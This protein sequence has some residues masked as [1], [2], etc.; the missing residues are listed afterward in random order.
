MKRDALSCFR[1]IRRGLPLFLCFIITFPFAFSFSYVLAADPEG[2]GKTAIANI[3]VVDGVRGDGYLVVYTPRFGNTTATNTH[4]AEAVVGSDNRVTYVGTNNN[5]TIPDGGFVVSGHDS[6]TGNKM[7]KWITDNIEVGDYVYFNASAMV[8]VVSGKALEGDG[9]YYEVSSVLNSINKGRGADAMVV[10]TSDYGEKTG[11]NTYG[12]EV[13]VRGGFVYSVGG[14]NNEIPKDGFVVSGHG[15]SAAFLKSYAVAGMKVSYS[16]DD[17]NKTITF[18]YNEESAINKIKASLDASEVFMESQKSLL[19]YLNY[20]E[21]EDKIAAARIDLEEAAGETDETKKVR[22]IEILEEE[23]AVIHG[24]LYESRPVEYRNVW[25]CP[26]QKTKEEVALYVESLFETGINSVS[27]EVIFSSTTVMPMPEDSLFEQD[28]AFG[29]FDV[30]ESFIDECHKRDMELNAW[31][32]VFCVGAQK[33]KN[34]RRSVYA[35]KKEWCGVNSSGGITLADATNHIFLNPANDECVDFLLGTYRWI[36]ESYDL[37]GFE[38]DYI[39]YP[40]VVYDDFGYDSLTVSKFQAAYKTD[41]VPEYD[42]SAEYWSDWCDFRRSLVTDFVGKVRELVDSAAPGVTLLADVGPEVAA[43][44][45]E[46]YQDYTVWLE[47]GYIDILKPM[48]YYKAA[49][50]ETNKK[51]ALTEGKFLVMGIGVYQPTYDDKEILSQ[52]ITAVSLG[53]DGGGY[54]DAALYLQRGVGEL[55]SK[56]IYRLPAVTP[57]YDPILAAEKYLGYISG[58]ISDV[59]IPYNAMDE[60]EANEILEKLGTASLALESLDREDRQ[61]QQKAVDIINGLIENMLNLGDGRAKDIILSDLNFAHRAVSIKDV[62]QKLLR[63]VTLNED[64]NGGESSSPSSE[65]KSSSE[66]E[67]SRISAKA[68]YI[69]IFSAV[70]A[71]LTASVAVAVLIL[72]RGKNK[73]K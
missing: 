60:G 12:Y 54:F 53:S 31:V 16:A 51:A 42:T 43:A 13:T 18:S 59:F 9:K 40:G 29:G 72:K 52:A 73:K 11:T 61:N 17:N 58:R 57:T 34:Y 2:E 71:V 41:I 39:R 25:V 44:K 4:G 69:A 27:L 3:T 15:K 19:A 35:K 46:L 49:I 68:K 30:L 7:R 33:D 8:V 23:A 10:Y 6:A 20:G 26:T 28:P 63:R 45:N 24:L 66:E 64:K 22:A 5:N 56:S 50:L 1:R 38:L 62:S 36:L 32:R 70:G 14:N 65:S 67:K 21:I 47:K 48:S 37:D 55:L